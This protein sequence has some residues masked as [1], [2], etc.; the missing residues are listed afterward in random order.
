VRGAAESTVVPIGIGRLGSVVLDCPDPGLLA[1]FYAALLGWQ[2]V[3]DEA[4]W[5]EVR[6]PSGPGLAFQLAP[7]HVPPT[8]P[9][10]AVPQQVHLDVE[11]GDLGAAEAAV[12]ALGA[13][14]TGIPDPAEHPAV[15]FR[16]YRDPAGHPF[17]LCW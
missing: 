15:T 13:T 6:P 16:V 2:L 14:P 7:D 4:D 8:W 17:C 12:L 10:T 5:A 9:A 11:V 1:E 3:R